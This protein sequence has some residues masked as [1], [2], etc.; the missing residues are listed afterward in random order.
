MILRVHRH[1]NRS[2][3]YFEWKGAHQF[4]VCIMST[5]VVCYFEIYHT[6]LTVNLFHI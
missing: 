6:G 4:V 2:I 5:S 1:S 3:I